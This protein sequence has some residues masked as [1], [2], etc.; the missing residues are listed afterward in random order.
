MNKKYQVECSCLPDNFATPWEV[1]LTEPYLHTYVERI[2]LRNEE[3]V[4]NK[5]NE[6]K[7]MFGDDVI[8]SEHVYFVEPKLDLVKF[9]G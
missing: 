9:N 3:E 7:N 6:Y 5:L 4:Y 8:F 2:R 1:K